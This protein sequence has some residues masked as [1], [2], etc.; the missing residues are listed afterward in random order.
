MAELVWVMSTSGEFGWLVIAARPSR[1]CLG[2]AKG[3]HC[4]GGPNR[5]TLRNSD[6]AEGLEVM[7]ARMEMGVCVDGDGNRRRVKEVMLQ[8]KRL[9]KH[10]PWVTPNGN[11]PHQAPQATLSSTTLGTVAKKKLY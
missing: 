7:D 2:V 1:L 4:L 8:R 10:K 11:E 6:L 5:T 3:T 9:A